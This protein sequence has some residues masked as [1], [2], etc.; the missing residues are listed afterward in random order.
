MVKNVKFLKLGGSL[1][2]NKD[3]PYT[4]KTATLDRISREIHDYLQTNPGYRLILG[5]GSGSFGHTSAGL[6]NTQQ[7]VKSIEDWVGF[8]RVCH[9]ARSLNQLVTQSLI[10]NGV[11][12]ISFPPSAQVICTDH[13]IT[14]W[15]TSQIEQSLQH[16]LVPVVFG[17]AVF[18]ADIG[19]TILSTE[20]LFFH[21][22]G[23]IQPESILLAGIEA[24]VWMDFPSRSQLIPLITPKSYP[25]QKTQIL[26]SASP[27][28]TGGMRSKIENMLQLVMDIPQMIIQVFAGTEP[29]SIADALNGVQ[30]GTMI[31]NT[32]RIPS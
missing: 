4:V 19:G 24:G 7:G 23:L 11:P 5:H 1:I 17:D 27:D 32:E 28:V 22:A 10:Q 9:D 26:G 13:Q 30:I 15:D 12:A 14:K 18:D 20:D 29:G 6:Y 16:G 21:L 25:I 8:S 31:R 3:Q 2:T